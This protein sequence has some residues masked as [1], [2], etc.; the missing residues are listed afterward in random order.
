MTKNRK[1]GITQ[2]ITSADVFLESRFRKMLYVVMK[3]RKKVTV[4]CQA[5]RSSQAPYI[6]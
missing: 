2:E 5:R 6:Q 4:H 1:H 3:E